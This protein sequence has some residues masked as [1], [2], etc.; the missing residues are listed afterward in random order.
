MYKKN[1][2]INFLKIFLKH[3]NKLSCKDWEMPNHG[4]D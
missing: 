4:N 3:K 1:K 2:K